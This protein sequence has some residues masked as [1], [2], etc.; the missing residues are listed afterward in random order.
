MEKIFHRKI[1]DIYF[2]SLSYLIKVS[3]VAGTNAKGVTM[4]ALVV[5]DKACGTDASH[6]LRWPK[7]APGA[8]G[9]L[10]LH[11]LLL[12]ARLEIV[13]SLQGRQ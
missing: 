5:K 4:W 6:G 12:P 1:F 2:C 8:S 3:S 11:M 7:T 13:E 10:K 9:G